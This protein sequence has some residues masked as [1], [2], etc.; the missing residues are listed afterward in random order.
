[1]L[2]EDLGNS[3]AQYYKR[4]LSEDYVH[5]V[6][7]D[8]FKNAGLVIHTP[9]E[10]RRLIFAEINKFSWFNYV[11]SILIRITPVVLFGIAAGY[12]LGRTEVLSIGMPERW[13]P[14]C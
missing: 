1:M 5:R 9:E 7:R 10:Q 2:G 14:S 4:S 13:P 12:F 8:E 6:L 3:V 11:V